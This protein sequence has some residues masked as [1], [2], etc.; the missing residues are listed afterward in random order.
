MIYDYSEDIQSLRGLSTPARNNYFYGKLLDVQHFILEQRYFNTKR[1][2]LNRLGL[3][4]GVMCGL[5]LSVVNGQLVLSPGV[6]IDPVGREIIVSTAVPLDPRQITDD[7]G[8][9]TRTSVEYFS[10]R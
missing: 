9:P 5:R 7:C 6:A 2:L 3:G 4:S 10:M 8:R 1:W